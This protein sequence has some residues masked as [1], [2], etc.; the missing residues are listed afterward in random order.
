MFEVSSIQKLVFAVTQP[1][2][3]DKRA[4]SSSPLTERTKAAVKAYVL[5]ARDFR[6]EQ[7]LQDR[8]WQGNIVFVLRGVLHHPPSL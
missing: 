4:S 1:Y 5:R 3:V 6:I 8:Q 2:R 7:L